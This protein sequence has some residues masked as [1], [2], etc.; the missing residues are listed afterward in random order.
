MTT[1][2]HVVPENLHNP[3]IMRGVVG[4]KRILHRLKQEIVYVVV[5]ISG[6]EL[7]FCS[8]DAAG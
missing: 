8:V 1:S 2:F 3:C 4:A 6:T 5:G 7:F